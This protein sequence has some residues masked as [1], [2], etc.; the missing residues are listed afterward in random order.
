LPYLKLGRTIR[1]ALADVLA[2]LESHRIDPG[3]AA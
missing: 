2:Y 1:Y 3:G